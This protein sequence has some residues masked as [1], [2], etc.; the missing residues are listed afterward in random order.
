MWTN[1]YSI[2]AENRFVPISNIA[3]KASLFVETGFAVL[4]YARLS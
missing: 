4:L 2:L 3:R 1:V